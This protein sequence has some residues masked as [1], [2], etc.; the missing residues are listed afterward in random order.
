MFKFTEKEINE[1]YLKFKKPKTYFSK[2]MPNCPVKMWNYK[3]N[4]HDAPRC[5]CI[6]DFIEWIN[7]Y[8]LNKVEILNTTCKSDPELEF[9]TANKINEYPY[10]YNTQPSFDLHNFKKQ[11]KCDFFI[12]NQTIEHL[13]NP[14]IAVKNIY[15]NIKPGGYVFT[16]VPTNVIPH[17]TPFHFANWTPMGLIML[18]MS[19][20]F[21]V[22]ETGQW[23]NRNYI[24]NAFINNNFPLSHDF[25]DIIKCGSNNEEHNVCGCWL[26]AQ[27]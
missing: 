16:S 10:N 4:N 3:W 5:L 13:Y 2:Q 23:G 21:K 7:K 19:V 14:F 17:S 1:I 12:F 8:N 18:F 26:L 20:G 22:K 15:D 6:I 25:P 27:K 24:Y 11:E 9:I